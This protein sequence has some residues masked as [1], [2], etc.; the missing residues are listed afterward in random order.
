MAIFKLILPDL[1]ETKL[2]TF[3]WNLWTNYQLSSLLAC[4]VV[5]IMNFGFPP[6]THTSLP[7][8]STP[9]VPRP[10]TVSLTVGSFHFSLR[11]TFLSAF[12][13]I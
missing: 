10:N 12:V 6:H 13:Y 1:K 2:D 11:K 4:F 3:H 8:L 5:V 9:D 7:S